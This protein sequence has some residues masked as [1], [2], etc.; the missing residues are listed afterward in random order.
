MPPPNNGATARVALT[1]DRD[2]RKFVNTLHFARTDNAL[3]GAGD[4]LAIANVVADWWQNSYRHTC[5]PQVVGESVV[6]TK[7]DP[8]DPIQ[9]TVYING[10]GD[11]ASPSSDPGNVTAAVSWRSGFAGRANRGR[12]YHVSPNGGGINLNDTFTGASLAFMSATANYLLTH[13]A[14]ASL[15]PVIYHRADDTYTQ[16]IGV[17][18]DQLV[19]S[20]RRRLAGRG[21]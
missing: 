14:A 2:T 7:Q 21:A 1:V 18:V 3:L 9:E 20:M 10:P 4:I 5:Q 16:I 8:A 6:A 11:Q 19:D 13:A 12:F 17:I 15:K